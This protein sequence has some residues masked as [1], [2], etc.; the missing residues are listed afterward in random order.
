MGGAWALV[1][2]ALLVARAVAQADDGR[3]VFD[4]TDPIDAAIAT[5][6][7]CPE[8]GSFEELK[9]VPLAPSAPS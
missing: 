3:V 6:P 9:C 2:A 7:R 8:T 1:A 5:A 4:A